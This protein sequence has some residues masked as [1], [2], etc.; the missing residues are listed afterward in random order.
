[1]T[2]P[3]RDG[4]LDHEIVIHEYTH[5]LSNRLVGGG[6]GI[7]Q[8]QTQGMGEGWSDFYGLCLLSEATDDPNGN[9]AAGAYATKNFYGLTENYY[10][11]IRRYPYST[12]LLKNPLTFKDIDPA[13]ASSHTGIARSP[14]A[15]GA[16]NQVHNEGEVWCVTLWDMRANL[17]A[18]HGWAA[19]NQ[20]A[21]QLT[22]DAMKLCPV[23]PN[24]LQS[25]DAIIQA[26]LV[27]SSGANRNELW[28]AFAKRGMGAS[29]SS[30]ASSTTTGLVEAYDFPDYLNVTP[31][32]G[33]A[34]AGTVGGPF[35][36]ASQTFTLTNTGASP[37]NWT[38]SK[39][40]PWTALS[41]AS[42]T[43][44]AGGN[45][46]VVVSFNSNANGLPPGSYTDNVSFTN[47]AS[48]AVISRSASLTVDPYTI[49]V[50]NEPFA[51]ATP[52]SNWTFTGTNT[53]RT[54]V[55][56]ANTPH[57]GTYHLT[58]DS[59]VDGSYSRNEATLTLDLSG[60][61]HVQ[62]SFWAKGFSDEGNGPPTAPFPS[63]GY[64]FDGVAI[65][66][67]GGSNWY[68]VQGLRDI[69]GI[70]TKYVVDLDP[71]MTAYGLSY[72]ANFKFRFNQYD[73]YAISTDGIAIDDIV[74][75]ET[76]NNT[77]A[78]SMVETATEGGAPVTATLSV[79]PAPAADL[80]VTLTSSTVDA[81]V[82]ATVLV[83]AGST[84]VTFPV[85]LYDDPVLDG[86]QVVTI[87]AT[88][89]SYLTS[90][91]TLLVHDNETATLAV[92]IPSN[93]I[94]GSSPP[95][96]S[97]SVSE[98]V[99]KAVTVMLV[100]DNASAQVPASVTIPTGQTTALFSLALPNDNLINGSRSATVS[101]T[102]QNWTSGSATVTV[103]D[104]EVAAITLTMNAETHESA[105]ATTAVGMVTLGGTAMTPVTVT[106]TSSDT[107]E[108]TFP[109][110]ITIPAGQSSAAVVASIVDDTDLDGT[111][112]VT[113]S[114]SALGNPAVNADIAVRDNDAASFTLS[115]VA[116]PQREGAGFPFTITALDVNGLTL[117]AVAGPVTQTAAGDAGAVS[118][119]YP[120]AT[121][122]N[123]VWQQ[124]VRVMAPA[125]NVVITV[126][127]PQA[128]AQSNAFDV[129]IGPRISVAPS[130]FTLDIPRQ[131]AKTRTLTVTNNGL[132]TMT[133]SAA[134]SQ[135]WLTCT[136]TNGNVAQGQSATVN[137]TFNAAT[138]TEGTST[139]QLNITSNDYT[140]PAVAVPV[141]LNVTAPVASFVWG[142]VPSP[143]RVNAPFPVTVTAKDAGGA[144]VTGYEGPV[145]LSGGIDGSGLRR[146]LLNS[147]TYSASYN[148]ARCFP[149]YR[150]PL[151]EERGRKRLCLRRCNSRP[152]SL[153]A[154][155]F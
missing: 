149:A 47:L 13:Q 10:F 51:A 14:N 65:S 68:E 75:S 8:N 86:T 61:Q 89:L 15:G 151:Q 57:A 9:Y 29:A 127:G 40:Q 141:T 110:T 23:N 25:R 49:V 6:V 112:T 58:M 115:P 45:T 55:T 133:W 83:P 1:G 42:G 91:K 94:E 145:T 126:T 4:D 130:S 143:Q 62:L 144:T 24:M 90:F 122:A 117:P 3:Y 54:Q 12:N 17:I 150:S 148:S 31:L 22:T 35:T 18:R 108:L 27:S 139:A 97:I 96:G 147:P 48:G 46:T 71:V 81:S 92:A 113:V 85:T 140:N 106:L 123:G 56:S 131:S 76:V 67:D 16:A 128:T 107:S 5:G 129:T 105:G 20:L 50:F 34:A 102:V 21:L 28:T 132:G 43:L 33:L 118:Y 19:G 74:V 36:P 154:S 121:F 53:Y 138:L 66:A 38:A 84:S 7:Y 80:T 114:A 137:V 95:Q 2:T 11:G 73:N 120:A 72:G 142:T 104:D 103:L 52:G 64:N 32:T 98:P 152:A 136:P 39:T 37:L 70:Y 125:T 146:T 77:L 82:P 93:A 79:T 134:G 87:S 88:A 26:D 100:S 69:S 59:S 111:Q 119:S 44:A 116:S 153:I 124:P 30:P 155:G 63:T 41:A 99:A 101:A 135:T 109:A 78:L 60:R